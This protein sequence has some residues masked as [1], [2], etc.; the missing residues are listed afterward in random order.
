MYHDP[1]SLE[2]QWKKKK[3]KERNIHGMEFVAMQ[4]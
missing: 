3:K 1:I 4:Q 2:I